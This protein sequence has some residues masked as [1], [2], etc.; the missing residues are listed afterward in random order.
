MDVVD[1]RARM[2]NYEVYQDWQRPDPIESILI[3]HSGAGTVNHEGKPNM[4]LSAMAKRH[5]YEEER[6]HVGY[7]YAINPAGR[8]FYLLDEQIAGYH[9]ALPVPANSDR[10]AMQQWKSDWLN[11]QYFNRRSIGIVLLGWFDTNRLQ[12]GRSI[13][14]NETITPSDAQFKA[15]VTLVQEIR[16]RYNIQLARVEGHREVLTRA[17]FGQTTCPGL[18][19]D[20]RRL[21]AEVSGQSTNGPTENLTGQ[22]N[23]NILAQPFIRSPIQPMIPTAADGSLMIPGGA[24]ALSFANNRALIGLH[25]RNDQTFTNVDW[26]IIRQA[27]IESLK[28]MSFTRDEVYARARQINPN[29][30]FIVR[31]YAGS[32]GRGGMPSP[33]QFANQF[34]ATIDRLYQKFGVL[35]FEI[36]NE[37]N[38]PSGLEGWGISHSDALA[39]QAWYKQTL[40]IF[41]QH[42]KWA[43]FGYPGLAIPHNDL[44]WLDWNREAIEMSDWL[45]MHCYWQTPPGVENNF[46]SD[47]WGQRFKAYHQKHPNK[48][49]EITEFGNSNGQSSSLSLPRQEQRRQYEWWLRQTA[50]FPYLGSAHSFLAT[51]PDP[52]WERE[53]FTW[54]NNN[55]PFEVASAVGAIQRVPRRPDWHYTSA[56]NLPAQLPPDTPVIFP[57]TIG[58]SGRLPW[59]K[60]GDART[61]LRIRWVNQDNR[62]V[63]QAVWSRLP[64]DLAPSGRAELEMKTQ[65]PPD[66]GSYDV[67]VAVYHS[68]QRKWFHQLNPNQSPSRFTIAIA[69]TTRNIPDSVELP[70]LMA[71]YS[72]LNAP[73]T[74][75]T[76]GNVLIEI[77]ARNDGTRKWVTNGEQQGSIRLGY[78]WINR[79]G[80]RIEGRGRGVLTHPVSQGESTRIIMP[81]R[82]LDEPDTYTLQIGMVSERERWFA[83]KIDH[84]I[85][86]NPPSA[87]YAV[88]YQAEPL[89]RLRVGTKRELS[90]QLHN[91]GGRTWLARG[92]APVT[93]VHQWLDGQGRSVQPTL[94]VLLPRDVPPNDRITIKLPL[95]APG[96]AGSYTLQVDM[97]EEGRL[98]FSQQGN[99]PLRQVLEVERAQNV[100]D[101]SAQWL[102][103]DMPD[104]LSVGQLGQINVQLRNVGQRIWSRNDVRLGYRW[105]DGQ[106]GRVQLPTDV[107][108]GNEMALG[109]PIKASKLGKQTLTLDLWHETQGWLQVG[110]DAEQLNILPLN[111]SVNT[112]SHSSDEEVSAFSVVNNDVPVSKISRLPNLPITDPRLDSSN[113]QSD[114]SESSS[115]QEYSASREQN[116]NAFKDELDPSSFNQGFAA[117]AAVSF[118]NRDSDRDETDSDFFEIEQDPSLF[119]TT[120]PAQEEISELGKQIDQRSD[121]SSIPDNKDGQSSDNQ[122]GISANKSANKSITDKAEPTTTAKSTSKAKQ[123]VSATASH[124]P[125]RA[126]LALDDH[127]ITS[128]SSDAPQEPGMWFLIDLGRTQTMSTLRLLSQPEEF[129]R[130][131]TLEGSKDGKKWEVLH[132]VP[133]NWSDVAVQLPSP[134]RLRY[135]RFTQTNHNPWD[136]P[137]S[138]R[139]VHIN[140]DESIM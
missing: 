56:I 66:V 95:L 65:T 45:G 53:G 113:T 109:L 76:N 84:S 4:L 5:V 82:Y 100:P 30:E 83:E 55:G 36:H 14:N 117:A 74:G 136:L 111:R 81:V 23:N 22:D 125:E 19:L 107:L 102:L 139:D 101:W 12:N 75:I 52:R 93:I 7:H 68:G 123:Q 60:A 120:S 98:F 32:P 135:L 112:L 33:Q 89:V 79:Q 18:Q 31:L 51:S 39:F 24:P 41:R 29:M 140:V 26:Q 8:V 131:Y 40:S 47:F 88:A 87:L 114:T 17:G 103:I 64:H 57:L 78:H 126:M 13:P 134:R 42:H 54:G 46:M 44:E 104:E 91:V 69:D 118:V 34:R 48:L 3:H 50:N 92:D 99:T 72:I 63:G 77:E 108:P 21:R 132:H 70:E 11:G 115:K 138:V 97:A 124:N 86:T 96:E 94:R 58:N 27:R 38:H 71:S 25:A 9:A 106:V 20:L 43:L 121:L 37:P 128:W 2:P 116:A 10:V 110:S 59:V 15:L 137:W 119:T 90:I 129:P 130:G 133:E 28:M 67:E 122:D 73:E 105:S 85:R 80:Q 49:I 127:K 61:S 1:I 62:P 16:D 6:A 35:K